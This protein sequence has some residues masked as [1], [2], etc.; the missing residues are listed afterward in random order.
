MPPLTLEEF[1]RRETVAPAITEAEV[2]EI[3][4]NAYENGF[5]AGATEAIAA[6]E[7][8]ATRLST[9][10]VSRLQDMSFGFHEAA[11]HVMANV[12]P[13]LK[14]MID[15]VLPR[16]MAETVGHTILET[17]EPL[18]EEAAGIPV[19]LLVCPAEA[20]TI[21]DLIGEEADLPFVIV[22]D[23]GLEPGCAHLKLGEIER[24]IDVADALGRMSEA[25]DAV[26]DQNQRKIANA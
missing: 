7:A 4:R 24:R 17:V 2:E 18:V 20:S 22:E 19:R 1:D 3:R 21:R 15:T 25:V 8:E 6:A 14:S 10:L 23:P 13:V 5:Q 12:T 11:A 16:M 26:M 9:D